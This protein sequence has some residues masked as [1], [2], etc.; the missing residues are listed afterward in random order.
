MARRT[1]QVETDK[2]SHAAEL[3]E[4]LAKVTRHARH[5]VENVSDPKT[6]ALFETTAE[7]LD[8]LIRAYDH[9]NQ[10]SE[11]AWT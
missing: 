4:M 5:E 7:V 1:K 10:K 11:P 8:G 2:N 6:Q 9:A 3:R